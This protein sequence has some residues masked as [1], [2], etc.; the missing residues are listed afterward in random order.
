MEDNSDLHLWIGIGTLFFFLGVP[1]LITFINKGAK[2]H[3]AKTNRFI[4]WTWGLFWLFLLCI[5]FD[6]ENDIFTV[7][8]ILDLIILWIGV[9]VKLVKLI[10]Y[11]PV[12][13]NLDILD[14]NMLRR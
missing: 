10:R 7:L 1:L 12:K 4:R 5:G 3:F 2:A 6:E 14:E 9:I 8:I 11:T 13:S